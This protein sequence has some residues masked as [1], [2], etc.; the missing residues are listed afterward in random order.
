M[1]DWCKIIE[2]ENHDVVIQ[3]KDTD[4]DGL[5]LKVTV[6]TEEMSVDLKLQM[7]SKIALDLVYDKFDKEQAESI[8][9]SLPFI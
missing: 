2:T 7:D 9:K 5:H 4:D 6:Q 1:K 8:L 3:K